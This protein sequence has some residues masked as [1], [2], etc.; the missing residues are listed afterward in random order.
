M[1]G[2]R[3]SC[4]RC[5]ECCLHSTPSLQREDIPLVLEGRIRKKDLF[6]IRRGETLWDN[7][8]EEVRPAADEV[9]KV[10]DTD[11]GC[12][13]YDDS[14][15]AC[16]IYDHRPA[17]C[18]ALECWDSSGFM[19]IYAGP[20]A[21][22]E[23]FIEDGVLLGLIREHQKRCAYEKLGSLVQ[24]IESKGEAA[25]EQ[26]MEVLKFDHHLRPLVCD[27]MGINPDETDF[28]FGRPLIKTIPQFGLRVIRQS[29]GS[30]FLTTL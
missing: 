16:R 18:V 3:D 7:V 26:I 9:I 4:I 28:L 21:G 14:R 8:S 12:V 1:T 30:F 17:Q 27:R 20:K 22:R 19:A 24:Q 15:K 25:V 6:T 5:G 2:K 11:G 23:D 13:F 10:R 29:D